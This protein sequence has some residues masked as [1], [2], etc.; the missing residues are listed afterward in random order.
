MCTQ[1]KERSKNYKVR[2]YKNF[3]E[4]LFTSE[5]RQIHFDEIKNVTNDPNEMW[6]IWKT[7]Y[8]AVLNRHAPVSDMK[9]KGNNLPY[10]TMEVR[11]MIRQRDY[12]RK[13]ANKTGSPILRQAFQQ[14]RNKVTYKIRSLRAEYFSKSIETNKDDLRKTWKILK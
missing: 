2:K 1:V 11:Q 8:L 6:L 3:D 4:R 10:I 13:K 5:L 9:I 14:I 12:L 7:W